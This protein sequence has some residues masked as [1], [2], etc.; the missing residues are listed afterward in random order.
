MGFRQSQKGKQATLHPLP[1]ASSHLQASDLWTNFWGKNTF[2]LILNLLL[3]TNLKQIT[4][5]RHLPPIPF[6]AAYK[7]SVLLRQVS[8]Q[9]QAHHRA[10]FLYTQN[11]IQPKGVGGWGRR[12]VTAKPPWEKETFSRACGG[13]N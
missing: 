10:F 8:D 5:Q 9:N 13:K 11:Y 4:S 3:K 12:A 1:T 7:C 2:K 6:L